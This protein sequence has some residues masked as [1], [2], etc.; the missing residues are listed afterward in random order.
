MVEAAAVFKETSKA[1]ARRTAAE[2]EA[3]RKSHRA[4]L[5]QVVVGVGGRVW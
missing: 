2:L 4:T 5:A 3:L 1:G